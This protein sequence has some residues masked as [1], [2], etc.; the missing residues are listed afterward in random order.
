MA[1]AAFTQ[2]SLKL[3]IKIPRP[4]DP[5]ISVAKNTSAFPIIY[6][7]NNKN[8]NEESKI[9]SVLSSLPLVKLKEIPG[10][11][12][13]FIFTEISFPDLTESLFNK[14]NI[15]WPNSYDDGIPELVKDAPFS[16]KLK[17]IISL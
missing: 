2:N 14:L 5:V 9:T 7:C 4:F 8:K 1:D 3:I 11:K 13:H 17:C 16:F 6:Y 12:H 15:G 10:K